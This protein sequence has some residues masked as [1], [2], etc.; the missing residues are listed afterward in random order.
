MN[1]P[2]ELKARALA[3]A[4]L[5]VGGVTACAPQP[6]APS[7]I[8][9]GVDAS[10]AMKWNDQPVTIEQ[11]RQRVADASKLTPKP[12]LEIQTAKDA[13]YARTSEIFSILQP[14]EIPTSITGGT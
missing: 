12:R 7:I 11:L 9:L 14:Y 1:D 8:H 13:P 3:A 4:A 6:T 2:F 10:G 5:A